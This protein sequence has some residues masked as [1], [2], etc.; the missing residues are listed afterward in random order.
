MMTFRGGNR[1][2]VD[3]A[4]SS[5]QFLAV[6]L[7]MYAIGWHVGA[8]NAGRRAAMRI[9]TVLSASAAAPAVGA[10]I[11]RFLGAQQ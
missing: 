3:R 1:S 10:A 9:A 5:W 6:E 8:P 2:G 7:L 11:G 4:V